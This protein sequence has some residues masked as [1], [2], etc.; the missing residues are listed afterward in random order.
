M[1]TTREKAAVVIAQA[2]AVLLRE[3]ALDLIA[4]GDTLRATV[5]AGRGTEADHVRFKTAQARYDALKG[6]N[7]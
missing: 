1:P 7:R 6:F 4:A 2:Q 3:A 5:Q